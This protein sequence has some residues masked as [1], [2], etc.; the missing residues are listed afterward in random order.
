VFLDKFYDEMRASRALSTANQYKAHITR[1]LADLSEKQIKVEDFSQDDYQKIVVTLMDQGRTASY[2]RLVAIA[3]MVYMHWLRDRKV[4][5]QELRMPKVPKLQRRNPLSISASVLPEYMHVAREIKEPYST[6]LRLL[7]MCGFRSQELVS[8]KLGD[9]KWQA[10]WMFVTVVGKGD[11]VRTIPLIQQA[12][13]ILKSYLAGWRAA[14]KGD[15]LFPAT[16]RKKHIDVRS[17]RRH[18][19]R[20]GMRLLVP[21]V[22]SPHTMRRTY[23]TMLR[24]RGVRGE[25]LSRLAGHSDPNFTEQRYVTKNVEDLCQELDGVQFPI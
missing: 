3:I 17:L 6:A 14:F 16:D 13:G 12:N 9:L 11:K 23:L 15:W 1:F 2:I 5:I 21:M 10:P 20:C 22:L 25:R 8:I 24:D 19:Q 18:M 4:P 7:P